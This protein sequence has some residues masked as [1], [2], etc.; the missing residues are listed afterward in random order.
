MRS[1][2][3]SRLTRRQ[4]VRLQCA[5]AG[6][7]RGAFDCLKQ[8]VSREGLRALYKGASPPAVSWAASDACLM[9]SMNVYRMALAKREAIA[10]GTPIPRTTEGLS[11]TGHG[12]AAWGA[13]LTVCTIVT[14]FGM[15]AGRSI[16]R[17][18][19]ERR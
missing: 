17:I 19:D 1:S 2:K 16:C 18:I 6:V 4:K 3:S 5:E 7:Y 8:T 14:P 13:G 11:I 10:A 9:G 15:L 12:L